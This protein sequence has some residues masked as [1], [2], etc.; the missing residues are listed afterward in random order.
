MC[1]ET[2]RTQNAEAN[3]RR[4]NRPEASAL[5]RQVA[6]GR[7]GLAWKHVHGPEGQCR[8]P[9]K[10]P[11]TQLI[12]KEGDERIHQGKDSPLNKRRRGSWTPH[13]KTQVCALSPPHTKNWLN[14]QFS[15][16]SPPSPGTSEVSHTQAPSPCFFSLFFPFFFL[17]TA[18][19][20]S[21][22]G[23]LGS[24]QSEQDPTTSQSWSPVG[25]VSM[26]LTQGCPETQAVSVY[27]ALHVPEAKAMSVPEE[28]MLPSALNSVLI[29]NAH[30]R[31]GSGRRARVPRQTIG[32][33]RPSHP[34]SWVKA[35]APK[36]S[37]ARSFKWW[38]FKLK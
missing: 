32:K 15:T 26:D 6:K 29:Q 10:V 7:V 24:C 36:S 31:A 1:V 30:S 20:R 8:E 5:G 16:S 17:S 18:S 34:L 3:L 12:H 4:E 14:T 19:S 23:R 9:R 27:S 22:E 38:K 11:R 33:C 2:W 35:Q 21:W 25:P 28:M 37:S 13:S